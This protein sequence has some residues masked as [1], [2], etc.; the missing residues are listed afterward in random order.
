MGRELDTNYKIEDQV[1]DINEKVS[2]LKALL[3]KKVEKINREDIGKLER[4]IEQYRKNVDELR[5][6]IESHTGIPPY[7]Q[8]AAW[9][10]S[11]NPLTIGIGIGLAAQGFFTML[12]VVW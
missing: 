4:D 2:F 6:G 7:E 11:I 8:P 3:G 9:I 12:P 5:T 1:F 10:E